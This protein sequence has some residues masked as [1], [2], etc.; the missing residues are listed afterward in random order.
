MPV[1]SKKGGLG[2]E[3]HTFEGESGKSYVVFRTT[4]GAFHVFQDVEAKAAARDCGSTVE[5]TARQ[6]WEEVW[7]RP[8]VEEE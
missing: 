1:K 7:K 5:G 2:L 8:L 6:M 3:M 4:R